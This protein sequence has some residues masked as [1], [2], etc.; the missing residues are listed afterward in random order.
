[1]WG[2]AAGGGLACGGVAGGELAG[3]GLDCDSVRCERP[4][5]P[6]PQAP[7]YCNHFTVLGEGRLDA[8]IVGGRSRCTVRMPQDEV[9][10]AAVD[11]LNG[12]SSGT[13]AEQQ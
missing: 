1:M 9:D 10:G 12:T 11:W 4:T 3:D 8:A 7:H 6:L 2:S 13:P 5:A